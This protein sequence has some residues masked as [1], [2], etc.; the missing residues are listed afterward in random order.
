[1]NELKNI[2]SNELVSDA[3][4]AFYYLG[5]YLKQAT[6]SEDYEKDIFDD[7]LESRPSEVVKNLTIKLIEFIESSQKKKC[8]DFSN[9]EYNHWMDLIDSVE[10]QL[11]STPSDELVDSARESIK[12]LSSPEQYSQ[13]WKTESEQL[14]SNNIYEQ[15]SKMIPCENTLEFGCGIG[16]GTIHLAKKRDVLSLDNNQSLIEQAM[17]RLESQGTKYQIHKCDFFNLGETEKQ[18]IC[19]FEPK[20]IVGWF[21]G[22]HGED[23]FKNTKEEPHPITK[24]KL[25]R[26]KIEDII[27]SSDVCIDS[28]EYINLAN[29]GEVV[30]GFSEKE[31][32]DSQK[33]DYDTHVFKKIGFE[34]VEVNQVE[35]VRE[36]SEFS[37]GQDHNPILA[38]GER[39]P[40]ITSI[41]AKRI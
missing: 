7:G 35:W 5:R 28:V 19:T 20:V 17:T 25:Y 32:F 23:I 27:I 12:E 15:L 29:R 26:E 6:I 36:K 21:I 11:D 10:S 1:M 38:K 41:I 39:V 3:R 31:I 30:V 24:S 16:N 4:S 2:V 8:F 40:V 37:Y 18:L 14:E 33:A 13:L 9:N 22:S 34:V